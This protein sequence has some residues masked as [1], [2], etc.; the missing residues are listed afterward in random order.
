MG[1]EKRERQKANRQIRLEQLAKEQQREQTKR[2]A[3]QVGLAVAAAVVI[4]L[5]FF[6]IGGDDDES[7]TDTTVATETTVPSDST[8]AP[9]ATTA[10]AGDEAAAPTVPGGTIEG[11][12][13]CPEAD[14]SSP[15]TITFDQAPPDCLTEGASYA[16]EIVTNRGDFTIELDA[17]AAP[18]TV[19]NFV[20]LARYHYF[21]GTECHRIV[22]DF[23]VQ[24]GDPTATGQGGPG[25]EIADEL[26]AS[27]DEYVKGAVAMANSGPDTNG[28]QFF[29]VTSDNG[30]SSFQGPDYSLFGAVTEGLDNTVATLNSL[31]TPDQKPSGLVQIESIT[32]VETPAA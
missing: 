14:G 2:R 7:P 31:G 3:L 18:G 8:E 4:A 22:P 27:V 17:E 16:A 19:N 5:I 29:V 1:T 10:A 11:E 9:A 24:C 32:I 28:S 6:L 12:A 13:P 20:F 21:D 26:P 23:V 15:R 25:Y 30:P